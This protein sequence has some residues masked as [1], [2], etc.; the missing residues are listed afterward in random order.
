MPLILMRF[1][2]LLNCLFEVNFHC[3]NEIDRVQSWRSER[4]VCNQLPWS[5]VKR[6]WSDSHYIL[7][8]SH[9]LPMGYGKK[10]STR[11]GGSCCSTTKLQ[12]VLSLLWGSP[13]SLLSCTE[14][15]LQELSSWDDD[16]SVNSNR[17]YR[18][19]LSNSRILSM[20]T[21]TPKFVLS[22]APRLLVIVDKEIRQWAL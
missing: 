21:S 7:S 14:L 15:A 8:L 5:P 4:G 22:F 19:E 2:G 18:V 1:R 12:F 17:E 16:C 11:G 13:I 10:S 9:S 20:Q 3:S 6:E